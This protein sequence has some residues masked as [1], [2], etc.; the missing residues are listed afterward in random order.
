[1]EFVGWIVVPW[2][3]NLGAINGF[4]S[5]LRMGEDRVQHTEWKNR[6]GEQSCD[7]NVSHI[8]HPPSQVS[9]QHRPD[10]S[11][12][13]C[14]GELVLEPQPELLRKLVLLPRIA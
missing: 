12:N 9:V 11:R 7:G 3:F 6:Q 14:D 13:Y 1:M 5:K 4:V 2:I 10:P 8:P